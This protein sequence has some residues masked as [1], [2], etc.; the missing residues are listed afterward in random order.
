MSS[1]NEEDILQASL[2]FPSEYAAHLSFGFFFNVALTYCI[3]QLRKVRLSGVGGFNDLDIIIKCFL[4][5]VCLCMLFDTCFSYNSLGNHFETKIY[6]RQHIIYG[7]FPSLAWYVCWF[8]WHYPSSGVLP[9]TLKVSTILLTWLLELLLGSPQLPLLPF[10]P[11]GIQL[12]SSF[13]TCDWLQ[14][15]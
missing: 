15:Y 10:I 8:L 3:P 13:L 4:C 12:S 5:C 9:D 14:L 7:R 1:G 6:T 2:S 11:W